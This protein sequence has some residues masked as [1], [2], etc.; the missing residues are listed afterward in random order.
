MAMAR[1][2]ATMAPLAAAF[3]D[4]RA[5]SRRQISA[6]SAAS[7]GQRDAGAAL[8]KGLIIS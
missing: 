4:T 3:D 7:C 5:P 6:L 2:A 1:L 8:A